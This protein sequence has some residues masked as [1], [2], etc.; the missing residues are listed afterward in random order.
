M[1]GPRKRRTVEQKAGADSD[2]E[3]EQMET[4]PMVKTKLF[5]TGDVLKS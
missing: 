4:E 2:N 1:A 5:N 3:N